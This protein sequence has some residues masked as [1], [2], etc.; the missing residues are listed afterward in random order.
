V[1]HEARSGKWYLA[2]KVPL[3][4]ASGTIVGLVG[5]SKD[6]TE[7]RL[8]EEKL[9]S[10]LQAFLEMVNA[11]S[12]GDLTRRAQVGD[13]TLGRIAHSVNQM[14]EAFASI[15]TDVR[16]TALSVSTSSSEILAASTQIARGALY[17]SDQVHATS[18]A[19]EEMAASMTSV[20]RDAEQ[21]AKSASQVLDHVRSGNQ[22]VMAVH[23]G[24][25]RINDAAAATSEKMRLLERRSKEISEIIN[26]IDEI[27]MQST[28]LSLNASIEAAHAGDAGRGFG[29]VA[30]EIRRLAE[31]STEATKDV[32]RIVEGILDETRTVLGAMD[33]GTTEVRAGGEL[34]SQARQSLEEIEHLMQESVRLSGQ[35]SGAAGEQAQATR[36]VAEGMQGIASMTAESAAAAA[37]SSKAVKDLVALAEQLNYA[38]SLFKTEGENERQGAATTKRTVDSLTR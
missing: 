27:A 35:I 3:K 36:T 28:L 33:A 9:E 31:R 30:D 19:I 37:E 14:L 13:D 24:M 11:A 25:R 4:D 29:V 20:S 26:L 2:T 23:D 5:I 34:S 16:E 12:Q 17:G 10:D 6:I 15:L 22:S 18:S 8:A 1:E 21:S 7:R 32:S 38:I